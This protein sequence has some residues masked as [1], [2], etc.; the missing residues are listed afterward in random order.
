MPWF[1]IDDN[2][3]FHHKVV[4]A[5]NAAIGL[6][7]RAGS[8]CAQNLTD[9]FVPDHMLARL[10]TQTQV[11]KLVSVGLWVRV[12]G[13]I[14][15]HQWANRQP[16]RSQV[17]AEREASRARMASIRASKK[18]VKIASPQVSEL[19]SPEVPRTGSDAFANPTRPDPTR[20]IT[21]S[22][23]VADAPSKKPSKKQAKPLP[24][25][26]APTEDHVAR[27]AGLGLDLDN[28]VGRFKAHAEANDRRQVNW[29]ASFT[30]WLLGVP[31]WQRTKPVKTR[32][33]P[34]PS[35]DIVMPPD[36]L[37]DEEY[38][39]WEREQRERRRGA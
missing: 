9:G 33:T 19:R 5:G 16:L 36:G 23:D 31:E 11:D 22:A 25:D 21:T 10:G 37:T 29:N 4:A 13:G 8:W 34:I 26:W 12:S 38:D 2:L 35:H 24:A 15:F 32:P 1:K 30:Q 17:E 27:A 20:P 39:R 6:W 7:A 18:G 3:A 28:Q 14:E